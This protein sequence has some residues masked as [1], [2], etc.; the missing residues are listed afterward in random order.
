MNMPINKQT[1]Y[2][3]DNRRD[4]YLVNN[5]VIQRNASCVAVIVNVLPSEDVISLANGDLLIDNSK[6]ILEGDPQF[7]RSNAIR[8]DLDD[9]TTAV[10]R[11]W[12]KDQDLVESEPFYHQFVFSLGSGTSFLVAPD[13]I[14]TAA[15]CLYKEKKGVWK[16]N[17][18]YKRVIFGFQMQNENPMSALLNW[19]IYRIQQVI[20]RKFYDD[21]GTDWAIAQLDRPVSQQWI[22]PIRHQ[23]KVSDYQPIHV[24]G[25]PSGLPLKYADGASVQQNTHP[26]FF[27]S[28]TDTYQGNSGSPIFNSQTHVV[29]GI[30]SVGDP[31]FDE[32]FGQ[33][34]RNPDWYGKEGVTR[35]IALAPALIKNSWSG[36]KP[37]PGFMGDENSDGDVAI[38]QL[39]PD[40]RPALIVAHLQNPDG[41]NRAYYQVGY[42]LDEQGNPQGG[43][44]E[45]LSIPS[46]FGAT[47]EGLGIAVADL[48]RNGRPD[49]VVFYIVKNAKGNQGYYRIGRDL[50]AAG[51]VTGGWTRPQAMPGRL[52]VSTQ[53]AGIAIADLSGKGQLH[54]ISF[55]VDGPQGE[56]RGFY[57]IGRNLN[58]DGIALGGWS[59][60]I[61]VPGVLGK[62]TQGAGVAVT[63]MPGNSRPHL[64][65]FH[66]DNPPGA[67]GNRAYYRIGRTLDAAG[68][69]TEG[70]SEV[71][72]LPG[73]WGFENQGGGIT[74]AHLGH[75]LGEHSHP[76]PLL[77]TFN[78]FNP[79]GG[80]YGRYR[81]GWLLP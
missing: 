68:N 35:T 11:S 52:G 55:Y 77:I 46:D 6:G 69:V 72:Q 17:F 43:W 66:L 74:V 53:G 76:H 65:V 70:W 73:E 34:N 38:A 47:T 13:V 10:L 81:V 28:N 45:F 5:A 78:I 27:F 14:A 24:I 44:S 62:Q 22:A 75:N 64:I 20:A 33:S 12:N 26:L 60:A 67:N 30:L 3:E 8:Y 9:G 7:E 59:E 63:Q 32:E 40:G 1:I 58:S 71:R 50:D 79:P 21:A 15:H 42:A 41:K 37:V 23:G 25:H 36:F 54:L 51:N 57:R 16:E 2:G 4:L 56:N 39:A 31:D 19:Q 49:L 61:R 48:N 18:T 80:N 29:E